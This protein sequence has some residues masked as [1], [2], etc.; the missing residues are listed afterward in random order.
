M[1]DRA[2]S[3][4]GSPPNTSRK[5][6]RK[7]HLDHEVN[8]K[9][10]FVLIGLAATCL[11]I[12]THKV[13]AQKQ[14][15]A[16]PSAETVANVY[17]R[18]SVTSHSGGALSPTGFRKTNGY[19]LGFGVY[20]M[21]WQGEVLF[22]QEGY[23]AGNI[24]VGYWQN[25]SVLNQKPG[26]LDSLIVGNTIFFNKGTTVRLT[27]TATFRKTEKSPRLEAFEVKTSQVLP[28]APPDRRNL[29]AFL[30]LQVTNGGFNTEQR[31]E[32]E[33]KPTDEAVDQ[34]MVIIR[35]RLKC[36]ALQTTAWS[37]VNTQMDGINI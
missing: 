25:F 22:Q 19:E 1:L 17:F 13:E 6:R 9:T 8:M 12:A 32:I 18:Y 3:Q 27:G 35:N 28:T 10:I 26:T 16:T 20:V 14:S 31:N 37:E 15:A 36:S 33:N 24:F 7:G 34:T 5:P 30:V 23:K 4:H 11:L 2:N 29:R 21:E